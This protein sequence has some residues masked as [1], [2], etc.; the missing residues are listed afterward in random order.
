M[1]KEK[2]S[3]RWLNPSQLFEEYGISEST[4]AKY[5]MMKKIPFSKVGGKFIK[6][7]RQKID[8]WLEAHEVVGNEN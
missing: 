7:D 1:E 3:K 2:H 5:R 8:N 4:Q 6:Y